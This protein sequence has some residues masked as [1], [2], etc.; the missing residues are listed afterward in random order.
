MIVFKNYFKIVK[1][2]L[3]TIIMF[4]AIAIGISVANT[5]YT[6]AESFETIEPKLAIIN[7]DTSN[8]SE[9]FVEYMK[10]HSQIVEIN[11]NKK[12]MQ[13]ALYT[14]KVD[15]IL[16]IPENFGEELIDGNKPMVK[17]KKSAQNVSEYTEI[18]I[19]RYLKIAEVYSKAGM[20]EGEVISHLN[21]DIEKEV[22]V[23]LADEKKSEIYKL[24]IFYSFEN[25]AFLSI[26][27]FII[28]TIMCIFNEETITKRNNISKLNTKSF[29]NQLF[30]GH[31]TL[32]LSIW[33]I[34]VLISILLYKELMFT[35]NGILLIIN[36]LCFAITATS[37][38]YLIGKFIK[39]QNVISGIQNV[40]ALGLSFISGCFVTIDLLDPSIIS[41][42]KLFPSYWFIQGNYEITKLSHFNLEI[43]KPILQNYIIILAFG[44]LYFMISKCKKRKKN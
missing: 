30:L 20:D 4:A 16:I 17:I 2:H 9:N 18:L 23:N 25:Y 43:L 29:S 42:S 26:F 41:F 8:L 24:A 15:T 6:S 19:N 5:T 7:N 44:I 38:A 31:L 1:R 40:V 10:K 35:I 11:D 14:N 27:I 22:N 28:G 36:S 3:G 21:D 12:E 34:F 33:A 37:L 39:N 13:D 32:T